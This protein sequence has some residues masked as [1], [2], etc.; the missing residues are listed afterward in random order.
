MNWIVYIIESSSG[1]LY[2]GITTNIERRLGEHASGKKGA[3]FFRFSAPKEILHIENYQTRSE[4]SKRE[5]VIKK[6]SRE[7]KLEL[8]ALEKKCS[9][10]SSK[11]ID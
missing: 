10:V 2:T 9:K 5:W 6:M 3:K 11:N 1:Y 4:A 7:K 8:I